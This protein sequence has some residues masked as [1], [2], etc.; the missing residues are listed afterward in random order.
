MSLA[1]IEQTVA[2]LVEKSERRFYGK[3]RGFVVDDKDPKKLARVK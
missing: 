3:H 1:H 2:R